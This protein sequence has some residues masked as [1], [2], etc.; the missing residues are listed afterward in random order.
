VGPA[1]TSCAPPLHPRLAVQRNAL[2]DRRPPSCPGPAPGAVAVIPAA[3]RFCGS[4]PPASLAGARPRSRHGPASPGRWRFC[5]AGAGWA[6]LPADCRCSPCRPSGGRGP[7]AGPPAGK[8]V[9][10]PRRWRRQGD[11]RLCVPPVACPVA[12]FTCA[13]AGAF[14]VAAA[15]CGAGWQGALPLPSCCRSP[16]PLAALPRLVM[17]WATGVGSPQLLCGKPAAGPVIPRPT[18]NSPRPPPR[19]HSARLRS[20]GRLGSWRGDDTGGALPS[21]SS[22]AAGGIF[23][24]WLGP[25]T[26]P[27]RTGHPGGGGGAPGPGPPH[28]LAPGCRPSP[29]GRSGWSTR[30]VRRRFAAAKAAR[31]RRRARLLTAGVALLAFPPAHG[32]PPDPRAPLAA[33]GT[34][35]P[36]VRCVGVPRCCGP[37]LSHPGG[38]AP[39]PAPGL[40]GDAGASGT[41]QLGPAASWCAWPSRGRFSRSCGLFAACALVVSVFALSFGSV[42]RRRRGPRFLSL[43]AFRASAPRRLRWRPLLTAWLSSLASGRAP[44]ASPWARLT[45]LQL[46]WWR[47]ARWSGRA[48]PLPPSLMGLAPLHAQVSGGVWPSAFAAFSDPLERV[49]R[50]RGRVGSMPSAQDR[51][52]AQLARG[53]R[54]PRAKPPRWHCRGRAPRPAARTPRGRGGCRCR[55]CRTRALHPGAG[56]ASAAGR[57]RGSGGPAAHAQPWSEMPLFDATL[58]GSRW[59]RAGWAPLGNCPWTAWVSRRRASGRDTAGVLPGDDCAN[60][61][62]RPS[63]GGRRA[64]PPRGSVP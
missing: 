54:P 4:W 11:A 25:P 60:P 35:R 44:R 39:S 12:G 16:P 5:V 49:C 32:P 50:W 1:F 48:P 62:P 42:R 55:W 19:E 59:P 28:L 3:A 57:W 47:P 40:W 53:W 7:R 37:R 14:A 9:A 26:P 24:W 34:G 43:R 52:G 8:A 17:V 13:A 33:G 18:G 45:A 56:E 41:G 21:L 61:S 36:F 31:G 20:R 58:P 38:R 23:L 46:C 64:R 63:R 22:R 10:P 15:Q 6:P 51:V 27:C 29:C 2:R 30:A